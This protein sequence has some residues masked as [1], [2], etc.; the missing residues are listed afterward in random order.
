MTPRCNLHSEVPLVGSGGSCHPQD[1]C[2]ACST[3]CPSVSC[4]PQGLWPNSPTLPTYSVK[5]QVLAM[6]HKTLHAPPY[7]SEAFPT[8]L[9]TV[10]LCPTFCR[11]PSL[12]CYKSLLKFHLLSKTY[13]DHSIV[14]K[15][16][17]PTPPCPRISF[18]C[19]SFFS[20]FSHNICHFPVCYII[21]FFIF[22]VTLPLL[23]SKFHKGRNLCLIC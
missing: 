22:I 15:N 3:S 8:S 1:I 17:N 18:L 13:P 21:N 5:A 19:S 12:T 4:P 11:S 23:E 20:F 9:P 10:S 2:K 16:A 7:L 6:T 14:L